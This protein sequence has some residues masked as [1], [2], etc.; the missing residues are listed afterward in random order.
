MLGVAWRARPCL[1]RVCVAR[2]GAG[3]ERGG[4]PALVGDRGHGRCRGRE[5]AREPD[6]PSGRSGVGHGDRRGV[7]ATHVGMCCV[8]VVSVHRAGRRGRISIDVVAEQYGSGRSA[9]RGNR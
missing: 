7:T 6:V 3:G 9:V 8:L 4:R 1:L 2:G 5:R